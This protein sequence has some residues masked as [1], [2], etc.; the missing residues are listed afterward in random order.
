MYVIINKR[1]A[2][3][4]QPSDFN[5]EIWTME[6][7]PLSQPDE[8]PMADKLTTWSQSLSRSKC[9]LV[10]NKKTE[11]WKKALYLGSFSTF[12]VLVFNV[13]FVLWAV[14]N[15]G[16]Q[17]DQAVL[18]TGNCEKSKRISTGFHFVINILGTIL[19]GASNYGMVSH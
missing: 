7:H 8:L 17:G 16:L 12:V 1:F 19:L 4:L 6:L 14:T 13:G 9:R 5:A 2:V 18:F 15:H 10:G 3:L 11:D